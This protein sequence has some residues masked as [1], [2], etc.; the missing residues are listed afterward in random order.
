MGEKAIQDWANNLTLEQIEEYERQGMDM[1]EYRVILQE[2]LA[3]EQR[4]H[5]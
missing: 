5:A 2:R 1:S 4:M 3:E